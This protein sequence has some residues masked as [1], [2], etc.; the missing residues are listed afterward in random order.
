MSENYLFWKGWPFLQKFFY[1]LLKNDII[2]VSLHIFP[3]IAGKHM[4]WHM[5]RVRMCMPEKQNMCIFSV[6]MHKNE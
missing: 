2:M 1:L 3:V 4:Y 5:P 6:Y